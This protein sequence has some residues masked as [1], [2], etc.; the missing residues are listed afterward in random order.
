VYRFFW[1]SKKKKIKKKNFFLKDVKIFEE[2]KK[3]KEL[4]LGKQ[5]SNLEQKF[6]PKLSRSKNTLI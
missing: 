4:I 1:S 3:P 5:L 2:S 6:L